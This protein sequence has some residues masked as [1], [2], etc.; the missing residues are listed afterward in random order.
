M[1]VPAPVCGGP[2]DRPLVL[3]PALL[4]PLLSLALTAAKTFFRSQASTQIRIPRPRRHFIWT[5]FV[6]GI[7]C[8]ALIVSVSASAQEIRYLYDDLGRLVGVVDQQGNA[9]E[10]V[11]DAVGNI[12]EIRRFNVDPGAAVAITLVSP[13]QGTVGTTVEIFGRGFS[14]TLLANEVAFNGVAATVTAAT[15]TSLTTT[16]PAG[17]TTGPITVTV[18][19]VGS[20][21]SPEPFTVLQAFAVTPEEADVVLNGGASFQATLDGVAT[22]AVTW[23][24]NGVV[25]GNATLG[26]IT[27]AGVYT[28]PATLP[29]V[30]PL[31]IEA[32]LTA[33]PSQVATATLR[34]VGQVAGLIA[35]QPVTVGSAA[36]VPAQAA[37]GPVTVGVIQET[38]A[39]AASGPVTV[40]VTAADGAQA[41]SG[42]VTVTGGPVVTA[43]APSSGTAGSTGV[44]VTVSGANLQGASAIQWIRNGLADTTLTASGIS[45]A[46]DG[47]TVSFSLTISAT[48][49]LGPR[50]LRV[51]TPQGTSTVFDIGTNLFTV[52]S[53]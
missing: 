36:A 15:G 34:V 22:S 31:T 6:P 44:G 46:P 13:N 33:D 21:T 7:L 1:R 32:V 40:G 50:V 27:A 5:R 29:P 47:A 25:G 14:A 24:V 18:S 20:A 45:P 9:A 26:T 4:V 49:P 11:H 28:A 16:V 10:Y 41:L 17:A 3:L 2:C 52:T 19:L 37:A 35:A 53:P 42:P 23:R 8:A 30:S 39:Q 38:G 12:L 51:T 43:V 48:A